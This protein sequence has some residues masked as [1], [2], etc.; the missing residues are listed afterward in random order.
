MKN[1][2]KNEIQKLIEKYEAQLNSS[3]QSLENLNN[4]NDWSECYDNE[5]DYNS[6]ICYREQ[7]VGMIEGFLINLKKII[8]K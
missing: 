3:T 2:M 8:Q 4:L 1:K 5:E 6:D 7:E